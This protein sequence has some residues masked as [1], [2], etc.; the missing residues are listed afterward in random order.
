MKPTH[1]VVHHT[2]TPQTQELSRAVTSINA[3]HQRRG[4][5]K[6]RLGYFVGYHYLIAHNGNIKQCREETEMGAHCKANGRNFDSIGICMLGDFRTDKLEGK[7]LESLVKLTTELVR[8]YKIPRSH[9]TY[10]RREAD[11]DPK[12]GWTACPGD[13][14][15]NQFNQI[16]DMVYDNLTDWEKNALK[17]S[18]DNNIISS[19]DYA[20]SIGLTI[21]QVAW[22]SEILRK[23]FLLIKNDKS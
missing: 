14:I 21:K 17:W 4:F 9:I 11:A 8:K 20:I 2:V 1:I 12:V 5:R 22:F 10:H 3:S 23:L 18:K 13:N 19:P 15:I 16:L 7:Q 6:S